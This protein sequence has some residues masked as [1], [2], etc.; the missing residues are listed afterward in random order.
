M[1]DKVNSEGRTG[2]EPEAT[3]PTMIRLFMW[4]V[5]VSSGEPLDAGFHMIGFEGPQLAERAAGDDHLSTMLGNVDY[6][7]QRTNFVLT[8]KAT[9]IQSLHPKLRSQGVPTSRIFTKAYWA[10]DK[11]GLD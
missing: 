2:R 10:P 4:E 1:N 3:G 7:D 9:S 11:K 8:G 6:R 5:L